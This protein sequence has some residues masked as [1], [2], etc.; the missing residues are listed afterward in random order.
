MV[1]GEL[2]RGGSQGLVGQHCGDTVLQLV[3]RYEAWAG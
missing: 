1:E 2:V 3:V